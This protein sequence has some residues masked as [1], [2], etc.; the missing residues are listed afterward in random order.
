MRAVFVVLLL[1]WS[2]QKPPSN[3]WNVSENGST[4]QSS[5][6]FEEDPSAIYDNSQDSDI[7]EPS[8]DE[9]NT[10]DN[11]LLYTDQSESWKP[12]SRNAFG[13][14]HTRDLQR[15]SNRSSGLYNSP[16]R[17]SNRYGMA[18]S[19]QSKTSSKSASFTNGFMRPSQEGDS[20]DSS[21]ESGGDLIETG[22]DTNNELFEESE[23]SRDGRT[24]SRRNPLL[25]PQQRR[26][27]MTP[28]LRQQSR[29]TESSSS[30]SDKTSSSQQGKISL[31]SDESEN[32]R[33]SPRKSKLVLPQHR[34]SSKMPNLRQQST[35]SET[36]SSK[37][38]KTSSSR[39]GKISFDSEELEEGVNNPLVQYAPN[40]K[41]HSAKPL[42]LAPP[43]SSKHD[44]YSFLPKSSNKK[45]RKDSSTETSTE[46]SRNSKSHSKSTSSSYKTSASTAWKQNSL[47]PSLAHNPL[48]QPLA[49]NPLVQPLVTNPLMQ[50]FAASPVHSLAAHPL[51]QSLNG[52]PTMGQ[53][54][55]LSLLPAASLQSSGY[56]SSS[57]C[58]TCTSSH[59]HSSCRKKLKRERSRADRYKKERDEEHSKRKK[60]RRKRKEKG[61]KLSAQKKVDYDQFL[62]VW[63]SWPV[64]QKQQWWN[65]LFQQALTSSTIQIYGNVYCPVNPMSLQQGY[66]SW[67]QNPQASLTTGYIYQCFIAQQYTT[68]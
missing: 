14:L 5:E 33:I 58:S 54:P 64:Q 22:E 8:S 16:Q 47:V 24:S 55:P 26:N 67:Q 62:Q 12:D 43:V 23:E 7:E 29:R 19:L 53:A 59:S 35:R 49:T 50:P 51:Y 46:S 20:T 38:D 40:H 61:E 41:K 10:Q 21:E 34:H 9:Y 2:L 57:D 4:S 17:G 48:V 6:E 31:E 68:F 27:A 56:S 36:S 28:S 13:S 39:K 52:N 25:F 45:K 30:D 66:I 65:G 1:G 3:I 15:R 42:V 37:S 44:I 32:D 11:S 60:D 63:G 18:P